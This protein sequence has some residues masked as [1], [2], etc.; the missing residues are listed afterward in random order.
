[1]LRRICADEEIQ[2]LAIASLVIFGAF[3]TGW[4]LQLAVAELT[5]QRPVLPILVKPPTLL[6]DGIIPPG[7]IIDR[8][9]RWAEA[10]VVW[11]VIQ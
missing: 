1:M 3:F 11:P 4:A 7:T 8:D 10:F 5:W 6:H 9:T 2:G